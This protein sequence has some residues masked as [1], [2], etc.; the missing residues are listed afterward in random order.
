MRKIYISVFAIF[1]AFTLSAQNDVQQFDDQAGNPVSTHFNLPGY[2]VTYDTLGF[3]E[4]MDYGQPASYGWTVGGY[5]YGTSGNLS[6]T[7]TLYLNTFAQA[8]VNPASVNIGL[9][10]A[11]VWISDVDIQS[12]QGCDIVI[13]AYKLNGTSSYTVGGTP[14]TITC[15]GTTVQAS[16]TFNINDVDTTFAGDYGFV[17]AEFTTPVLIVGGEDFA[18]GFNASNCTTLGDTVGVVGSAQG[19]P[20]DLYG[21]EYTFCFYPTLN[22]WVLFDHVLSNGLTRM[23]GVFAIVDLDYVNVDDPGFFQGLQLT[24]SPNPSADVISVAYGVI[25]NMNLSIE[26]FDMHGR[27]VFV[28]DQGLVTAGAHSATIDISGFAAGTYYCSV[29]SETG[30]LTKKM[31]VQ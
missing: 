4:F 6:S 26:I 23:P 7:S 30:R 20:T 16:Y 19:L 14:Y 9:T 24:V 22:K 17:T 1:L 5:V 13:N 25:K 15:P 21:V 2:R 10:G 31:I 8:Y 11:L 12:T 29:V 3:N 18:I 27:K 28:S